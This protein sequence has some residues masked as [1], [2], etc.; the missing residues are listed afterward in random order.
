MT[1]IAY[2]NGESPTRRLALALALLW[3]DPAESRF[4]RRA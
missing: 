4:R 1:T 3:N 2:R